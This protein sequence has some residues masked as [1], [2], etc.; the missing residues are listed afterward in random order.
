M[1]LLL[2]ML[3]KEKMEEYL[4][5]QGIFCKSDKSPSDRSIEDFYTSNE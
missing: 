4:T 3:K 5:V 1:A 2:Q